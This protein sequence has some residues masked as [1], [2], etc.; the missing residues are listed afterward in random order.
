MCEC[1]DIINVSYTDRSY[2]KEVVRLY[3]YFFETELFILAFVQN[4]T[5]SVSTGIRL[6][7]NISW[8][9]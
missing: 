8:Q 7:L 4:R 6:F 2:S 1:A 3:I 9:P 5:V